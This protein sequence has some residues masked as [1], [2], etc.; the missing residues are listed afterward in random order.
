MGWKLNDSTT[1]LLPNI[2]FFISAKLLHF[3]KMSIYA[4]SAR[5]VVEDPSS[6]CMNGLDEHDLCGHDTKQISSFLHYL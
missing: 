4:D 2:Y 3:T 5:I 1:F 6:R